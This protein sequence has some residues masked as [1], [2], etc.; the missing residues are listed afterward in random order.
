MSVWTPGPRYRRGPAG[1]RTAGRRTG[2]ELR[3]GDIVVAGKAVFVAEKR[4]VDLPTS[5]RPRGPGSVRQDG[6]ARRDRAADPRL[7]QSTS[8]PQRGGPITARHTLGYQLTSAGIDRAGAE[9]APEPTWL[10]GAVF[11]ENR[12]FSPHWPGT[13]AR[14]SGPSAEITLKGGVSDTNG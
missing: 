8:W 5:P 12:P 2:T 10:T 6:Q 9:G 1:E 13:E 7:L 4:Y 14:H 3:D 11:E